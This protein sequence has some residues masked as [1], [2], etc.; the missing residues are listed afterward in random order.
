MENICKLCFVV[1]GSEFERDF[2][3]NGGN[4]FYGK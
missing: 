2:F 4:Y 1:V 3:P